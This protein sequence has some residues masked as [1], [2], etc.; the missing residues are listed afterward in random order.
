MKKKLF[1]RVKYDNL[2]V[3]GRKFY[4]GWFDQKVDFWPRKWTLGPKQ[5]KKRTKWNFFFT[6]KI[7][8]FVPNFFWKTA[9]YH[10]PNKPPGSRIFLVTPRNIGQLWYEW[11]K[12]WLKM[13]KNT[14][15]QSEIWQFDSFWLNIIV[16]VIRQK[17]ST[18]DPGNGL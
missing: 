6:L 4:S 18:F 8:S 15:L 5:S 12:N 17:K 16:R 7:K 1:S 3:F 11:K 9:K 10:V 2:T 13:G 14:F